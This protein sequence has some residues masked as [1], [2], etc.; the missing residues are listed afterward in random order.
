MT[1]GARKLI[2]IGLVGVVLMVANIMMVA[3]WLDE[4]GVVEGAAHLRDEYLTGT[5]ITIIVMLLIL[6]VKPG[7]ERAKL[8]RRCPVCDHTGLGR[9]KYCSECGSLAI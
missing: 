3:Y 4:M 9:G 8:L 2:V 7:G 1:L 6:L 5:A